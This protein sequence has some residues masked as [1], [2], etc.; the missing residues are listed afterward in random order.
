MKKLQKIIMVIGFL[1]LSGYSFGQFDADL[2]KRIIGE[3]IDLKACNTISIITDVEGTSHISA[4]NI[5]FDNKTVQFQ[6]QVKY[7]KVTDVSGKL[8][9]FTYDK[10]KAISYIPETKEAYSIFSIYLKD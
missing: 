4:N 3:K 8:V 1:M 7:I 9:Y 2:C 6:F 5:L 10:I